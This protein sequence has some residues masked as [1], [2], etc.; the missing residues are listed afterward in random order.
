[1]SVTLGSVVSIRRPFTEEPAD[2][3]VV[4]VA[5]DTVLVACCGEEL[6]YGVAELGEMR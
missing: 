5:R 3:V 4:E 2:G 1:M 6:E